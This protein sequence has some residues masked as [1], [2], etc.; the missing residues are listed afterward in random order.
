MIDHWSQILTVLISLYKMKNQI[1]NIKKKTEMR[2][3]IYSI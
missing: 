2:I 3:I 1:K